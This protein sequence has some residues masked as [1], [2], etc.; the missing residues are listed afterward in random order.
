MLRDKAPG[1]FGVL[2]KGRIVSV[3][4]INTRRHPRRLYSDSI[5][6]CLDYSSAGTRLHGISFNV[7]DSGIGL[8]TFTPVYAGQTITV[9]T[10]LPVPYQKATV[11]W[12]QKRTEDLYRV[13]LKFI[14]GAPEPATD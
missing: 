9:E 7:S 1:F 5:A 6:F 12:V 2:K 8:Y 3:D 11:M 13:G 10:T 4:S 14:R